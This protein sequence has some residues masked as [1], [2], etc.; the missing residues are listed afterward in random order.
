MTNEDVS[1]FMS[2]SANLSE[3]AKELCYEA[4][5]LGSTDNITVVVVDLRCALYF[6]WIINKKGTNLI[7]VI[8]IFTVDLRGY[9]SKLGD[10]YFIISVS[11]LFYFL[12][13]L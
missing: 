6:F 9:L 5:I 3:S 12:K 2:S 4:S 10:A 8:L 1:R 11:D 7:I 13:L